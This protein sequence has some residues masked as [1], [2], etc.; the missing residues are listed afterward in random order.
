MPKR[1]RKKAD[2][3]S[4]KPDKTQKKK[5]GRKPKQTTET[6]EVEKNEETTDVPIKKKRGRPKKTEEEKNNAKLLKKE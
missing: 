2:S 4:D 1:G 3:D 6:L 5:P